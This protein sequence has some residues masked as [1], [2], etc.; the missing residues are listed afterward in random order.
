M[1]TNGLLFAHCKAEC[2]ILQFRE[3]VVNLFARTSTDLSN[4]FQ[5]HLNLVF[6]LSLYM[7]N[8]SKLR[9]TV[10]KK[11]YE[12][13]TY[14]RWCLREVGAGGGGPRGG[15]GKREG[16]EEKGQKGVQ[17]GVQKA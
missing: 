12:I 17:K 7:V 2:Q 8:N 10:I 14:D 5:I 9:K 15:D 3:E 13:S 11:I 1:E 4:S 6:F 16:G